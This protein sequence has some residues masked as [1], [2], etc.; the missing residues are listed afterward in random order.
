M[1]FATATRRLSTLSIRP[2][3]PVEAPQALRGQELVGQVLGA[4][5]M[6]G[7]FLVMA[8]FG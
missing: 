1:H 5:V 3:R 6:I 7:L 4:C 2:S 8:M